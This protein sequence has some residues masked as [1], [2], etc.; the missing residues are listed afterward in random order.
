MKRAIIFFRGRSADHAYEKHFLAVSSHP[1]LA[2]AT[3]ARSRHI[4]TIEQ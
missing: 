2:P 4:E 3:G 1:E